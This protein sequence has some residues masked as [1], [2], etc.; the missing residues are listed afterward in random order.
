MLYECFGRLFL[1]A[2]PLILLEEALQKPIV[3]TN[4]FMPGKVKL[5]DCA[6]MFVRLRRCFSDLEVDFAQYH[7]VYRIL[8][9]Q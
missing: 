6:V 8:E 4:A 1:R 7:L 3:V 2:F 9:H 5:G